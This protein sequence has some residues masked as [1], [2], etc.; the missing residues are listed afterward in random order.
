MAYAV[1]VLH[2]PIPQYFS[3][4]IRRKGRA[5]LRAGGQHLRRICIGHF[6]L[7]RVLR[8]PPPRAPCASG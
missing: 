8:A 3:W 2:G 5:L 7:G 4:H 6:P 1:P